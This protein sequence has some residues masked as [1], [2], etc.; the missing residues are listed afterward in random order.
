MKKKI[1]LVDAEGKVVFEQLKRDKKGTFWVCRTYNFTC[2]V[3]HGYDERSELRRHL[4]DALNSSY[5]WK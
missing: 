5:Y 3:P 1:I 2:E 4:N